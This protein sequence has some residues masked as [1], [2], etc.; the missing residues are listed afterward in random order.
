MNSPTENIAQRLPLTALI[1][2]LV[3]LTTLFVTTHNWIV[4]TVAIAM[5]G[6][7]FT[8]ARLDGDSNFVRL[9]RYAIFGFILWQ[10]YDY[11]TSPISESP[12]M[13]FAYTVGT[14]CAVEMAIQTWLRRPASGARSP[15]TLLLSAMVFLAASN[16]LNQSYIRFF[17]PLY[18]L[19]LEP[20]RGARF[21]RRFSVRKPSGNVALFWP[22]F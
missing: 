9:G 14:L 5:I 17:T 2:S 16:T 15:A 18:F 8:K 11:I 22:L 7:L 19:F 4:A 10:A 12:E 21:N 20:C 3:A 13:V 6:A 1:A